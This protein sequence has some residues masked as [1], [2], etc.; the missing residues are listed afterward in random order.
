MSAARAAA[1]LPDQICSDDDL[2]AIAATP[3]TSAA[4]LTSLTSFGPIAAARLFPPIRRALDTVADA[5][6]P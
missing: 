1:L 5:A 6:A 2:L 3:P 4:E